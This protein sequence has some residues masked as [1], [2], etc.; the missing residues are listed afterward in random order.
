MNTKA[1]RRKQTKTIYID[2]NG[3]DIGIPEWLHA[4]WVLFR[5]MRTRWAERRRWTQSIDIHTATKFD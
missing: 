3:R 1:D 2:V 5:Y 4:C